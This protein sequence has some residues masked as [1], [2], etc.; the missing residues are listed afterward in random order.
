L[1]GLFYSV[2]RFTAEFWREPD[3]QIGFVYGEWM[4]KGQ[5]LSILMALAS[6]VLYLLIIKRG[7]RG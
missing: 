6:L 3:F 2:G 7:K 1:Y 4:S 5:A